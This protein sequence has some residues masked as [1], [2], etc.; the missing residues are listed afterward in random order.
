MT[1][2]RFNGKT[3]AKPSL[4]HITKS[5]ASGPTRRRLPSQFAS[6]VKVNQLRSATEDTSEACLP[7]PVPTITVRRP[8]PGSRFGGHG[9]TMS[10]E[11]CYVTVPGVLSLAEEDE[12]MV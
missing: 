1:C 2:Q 5:R 8:P 6:K 12:I 10:L 7:E 11:T 4:P 9:G 3:A